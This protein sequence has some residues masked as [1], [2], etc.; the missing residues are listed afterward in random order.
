VLDI[1]TMQ[2]APG[3]TMQQAQSSCAVMLIDTERVLVVG[4]DTTEVLGVA[5][6]FRPPR[7]ARAA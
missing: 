6:E 2:F 5:A 1:E 4:D 7:S 3:P